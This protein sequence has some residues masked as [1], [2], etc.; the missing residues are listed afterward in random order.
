[1]FKQIY[2][3]V[4]IGFVVEPVT[5]VLIRSG[6]S[7]LDPNRPDMEFVRVK[8]VFGEA[9]YLPGSS[10]KGVIRSHAERILR[11]IGYHCCEVGR[12]V[13]KKEQKEN[14]FACRIFGSMSTASRMRIS[15]AY[16]WPMGATQEQVRDMVVNID[17]YVPTESRTSVRIDRRKG[18]AAGTALFEAEAVTGGSFCGEFTLTNYQLW[19]LALI[20]LVIRDIDAGFQRIGSSKSRGFGRV[21][22]SVSSFEIHQYGPLVS[23]GRQLCGTGILDEQT[24]SKYGL[25][26]DDAVAI[27]GITTTL[28]EESI[29]G[30]MEVLK[31]GKGANTEWP[32]MIELILQSSHW[33]RLLAGGKAK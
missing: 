11:S 24:R 25:I 33:Q 14:C 27:N 3:R 20:A 21:T 17:K 23:G 12:D 29:P 6:G 16:P 13:C 4:R 15:D 9:P 2:N 5:P 26:G 8:T 1:M 22:V 10:L 31:S 28:A 7:S 18:T 19:Q 32:Q 30:L